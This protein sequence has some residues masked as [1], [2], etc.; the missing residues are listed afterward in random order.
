MRGIVSVVTGAGKT[1]FAFMCM[2]EFRRRISDGRIWVVVPTLSLLDQWYAALQDEFGV[3]ETEIG[4]FSGEEHSSEY[5]PT[6]IAVLNTASKLLPSL[7][8]DVRQFLVVDECHRAATPEFSKALA[9][10]HAASLGLSATPERQYDDGLARYLEPALGSIVFRYDYGEAYSDGI[11]SEFDLMNVRVPLSADE[12]G[13]YDELTRK[14][15]GL[16][17]RREESPGAERAFERVLQRRATISN[18]AA[19]RVPVAVRLMDGHR[20]ARTLVF[21]ERIADSERVARLLAAR[22]HRVTSYHSG[23]GP[24]VRRSNLMLFRRGYKDV[25]VACRALDEGIDVPDACVAI[26]ASGSASRRQRI[27]RLG[28]VL[29][30]SPSGDAAQVYTLYATAQEEKRLLKEASRLCGVASVKWYS[31]DL[32]SNEQNLPG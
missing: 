8:S 6:N 29:R 21:S 27:Q 11:L 32:R 10:Q 17:R 3:P 15:A 22:G 1:V 14:A 20:G 4:I 18:S 16:A 9:V 7:Q 2:E 19:A 12:Q 24:D 31:S 23:I 30:P 5:R 13:K 28:R 26:L 25:I